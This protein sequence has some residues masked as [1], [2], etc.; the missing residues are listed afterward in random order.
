MNQFSRTR[1]EVRDSS[2]LHAPGRI[3]ESWSSIKQSISHCE[4]HGNPPASM[5]AYTEIL[6]PT[7]V[8]H[9]L[10]LP[11]VTAEAT[12]LIV[13]KTSLL[14][15]FSITSS[16]KLRLIGEYPLAGTV[17][18]LA[19]VKTLESSSRN[20]G[21]AL[22]ISFRDAKLSLVEWDRENHRLSTISIHYY[23]GENVVAP[24]FEQDLGEY[25]SV[26]AVDPSSRCAALKF[27]ARQLA[28]LPIRQFGDELMGE[29]EGEFEGKAEK[30]E[31]GEDDSTAKT[32]YKASFVLPMTT[33]DP[34]LC[35]TVHLAFLYEYREPTFGI[36]SSPME[37][38]AALFEERKDCLTYTVFTLD[39]EQKAST[40]L[41]TVSKL[42]SSLWKVVPLPLPVGGALLVGNNELVHIDQS[43]KANATAV[44]EFA[45]KESDFGMADQSHLNLKLEDCCIELLDPKTGELLVVLNDGSLATINFQMLGRAVSSV[46]VSKVSAENGGSIFPAA[47]SCVTSLDNGKLFVGSED[48]V[49]SLLGWTRPTPSLARKRSHAQMLGKDLEDE[50]DEDAIDED[51]DDLYDAAP[52]TKKRATSAADPSSAD[53]LARFE[54]RDALN[55]IGP[56]NKVC[57]GKRPDSSKDKLQL[58]AGT[59]R[60]RSSRLTCLNRDIVPRTI[61]KSQFDGAKNVWAIHSKQPDSEDGHD[62]LLFVYDGSDTQ[63]YDITPASA[64]EA[65]EGGY[66]GRSASEFEHEGETLEVGTLA[67]GASV[68]QIRK[69]EIRTYD[70]ANLGLNQII[71]MMDDD[72]DAEFGIVHTSFCDPYLLVIRDDSSILVL[73]VQG[74]EIEPLDNEGPVAEKKW[75]SGSVYSGPLTND[76]PVLFL[77]SA[78]GVVS[79]FSLPDLKPL[80]DLPGI[81]HLPAVLS[82]ERGKDR[83]A[84]I[85][86]TLTELLVADLGMGDVTSSYLLIRTALDDVV[87]YEPFLHR[88]GQSGKTG[89]YHGL[90]FRKVPVPYVPK[91]NDAEPATKEAEEEANSRQPAL[92][93]IRLGEYIAVTIPGS[94]P[95]VLLKEGTSPPKILEICQNAKL[96][97]STP[98]LAPLNRI[99]CQH[100]FATLTSS[101]GLIEQT[102]PENTWFGT[103]WSVRQN[104]LE[105]NGEMEEVRQLAY[106]KEKGV[107][108]VGTCRKVDFWFAK[109]DGRHAE[110]DGES[111]SFLSS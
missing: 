53:N 42:P 100:G 2:R 30:M 13:A 71:P 84:G 107:W 54:V 101:G 87:L 56:I 105:V 73:Q 106:H 34:S 8:T 21:E 98:A 55:S 92:K 19:R 80:C 93:C 70:A 26:L 78:D 16:D 3:D 104:E 9:A 75:L 89:W 111:I 44:N 60:G 88:D 11:F 17:T 46:D 32:P 20:T 41:I 15:V 59:G 36:L 12:N 102:L 29:E 76:M 28:I 69:T 66:I 94:P 38:S 25:E 24:P 99:D 103:G 39:L 49:S 58:L 85:K 110:Q 37:P 72:T 27:G 23:E 57:L 77:L 64:D 82:W 40:N 79:M 45:R 48:G 91:Y 109:E 81:P 31:E 74:K 61:R 47:A 67:G 96:S 52:E 86:E 22:L 62:N 14:Q 1:S 63:V 97:G 10:S 7:A 95:S 83:R 5:Q 35:H 6:P 18:G 108:V 4:P 33:L 65:G 68:V 51:D 90:R 43:G 50:D